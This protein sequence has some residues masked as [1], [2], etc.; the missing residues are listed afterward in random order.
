MTAAV[1]GAASQHVLI[2]DDGPTVAQAIAR[3][4]ADAGYGTT[5][6]TSFADAMRCI[7]QRQFDAALLDLRLLPGLGLDLIAPLRASNPA[8]RIL[9]YSGL[10]DW[11]TAL[12]AIQLGADD[13][14]ETPRRPSD[15]IDF[16]R[17]AQLSERY[18]V[19][20]EPPTLDELRAWHLRGALTVCHDNVSRT[21]RLLGISRSSLQR[22]LL[23]A[24]RGH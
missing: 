1:A 7:D 9:V 11:M 12:R 18:P 4:V 3:V 5:C 13:Y 16:L 24:P 20:E 23:R 2:V 17:G 19:A 6:A 10:P 15:F 14:C 8:V 21:A 22:T